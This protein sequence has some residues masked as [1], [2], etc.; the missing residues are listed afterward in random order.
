[1]DKEKGYYKVKFYNHNRKMILFWNGEH[2]EK[3]EGDK[4]IND[5]IEY[6]E[7]IELNQT[8]QP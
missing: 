1:M 4:R 3:F 5:E 7:K 6:A 2:F 8:N